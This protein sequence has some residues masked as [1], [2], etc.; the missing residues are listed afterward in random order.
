MLWW[1]VASVTS[2][3]WFL[4]A[5]VFFVVVVVGIGGHAVL[6]RASS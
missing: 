2:V 4:F 1:G 6:V 3:G 5:Q